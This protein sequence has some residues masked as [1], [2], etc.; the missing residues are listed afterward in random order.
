MYEIAGCLLET[1]GDRCIAIHQ[2]LWNL[3]KNTPADHSMFK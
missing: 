2:V 3:A 1:Y